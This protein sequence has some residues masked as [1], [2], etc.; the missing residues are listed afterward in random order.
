MWT[1]L[2]FAA[3]H[4]LRPRLRG[5]WMSWRIAEFAASAKSEG[6]TVES[7]IHTTVTARFPL[8]CCK[9]ALNPPLSPVKYAVC[10]LKN[11]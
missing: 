9:D 10:N 6:P 4:P 2:P 1:F 11:Q 7:V 8:R 5:I 3:V